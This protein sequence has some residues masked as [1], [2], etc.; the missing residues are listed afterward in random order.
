MKLPIGCCCYGLIGLL[1]LFPKAAQA[2]FPQLKLEVICDSQLDSPI[3]MVSSGDGSGRLFIAEQRGQIRIFQNGM[4]LPGRFL[5]LG[6]LVIPERAGYDERGLLGLAFHPEFAQPAA[7]GAG[8]FYVLYIAP[9]PNA[10]GITTDPVDSRTVLAE[11]K[12]SATDP[13]RADPATARVLLSFDKPQFNHAGGGLAFGPDGML[14]FT[15]GDGGSSNDN[16]F[17]HT[18]GAIPRLTSAKG[19]AQDLTKFFGKMH[20]IDPLGTNGPG[21]QYG[22]PATNPFANPTSGQ[23][24]EI[25]AYGLRNCWRFSFDSRPG[26]TGR[27]FAADVGQNAVEE[28]NIITSGGNY[29]WRNLEGNFVPAF[30]IDAPA[31]TLA[32]TGPIGQ[33][34]HPGVNIGSP[35]LPQLGLSVTGGYVYRGS[36]IPALAGKYVFGD[37]SQSPIL[38]PPPATPSAKGVMLGLEETTPGVWALAQLDIL[39]GNPINRYI[40]GFGQ[41]DSGEL[42]VLTKRTQPVTAPDPA[43]GLPSGAILKIVPVPP[44]T[45]LTLTAAKDNTIFQEAERSNGAGEWI[46]AG[47]TDPSKND[48]AMRRALLGWNLAT[49]PAGAVVASASVTLK[50]DRTIAPAYLFSLHKLTTNWGEGTSSASIQEGDGALASA[51]D[52]TWLKP[53]FGQATPWTNPGG[54]FETRKSATLSVGGETN[55]TW[56]GP[57]LAADA[58]AWLAN[59]AGNF[60]WL[61]K[62]DLESALKTGTG[63]SG[64]LAITVSDTDD[65]V[66]GMG[67]SGTGLGPGAKIAVGGINSSTNVLTLTA[68]NASAV[69]GTIYFAA[70]SA[71][72][73][74]SRSITLSTSRP[75][76]VLTYVPLPAPAS[77]RKA[78]ELTSYLTGQ[79]IEDTYDT[80]GDGIPDGV[81]Y[82]WGFP[83]RTP[84]DPA[85]GFT[86]NPAGVSTGGPVVLT[87]RRDPL[88][89]D[90]T[91]RAQMSTDL[92]DWT[93]LATSA[94]GAVPSGP[95][96]VSEAVV[97][98]AFRNVTVQDNVPQGAARRLYRLK[99]TRL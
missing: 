27:L 21:G 71:K 10:P 80:D 72:R 42:Y 5:D 78:W 20:R 12:V 48:A 95:G 79:F 22:I 97:D 38:S 39:G 82:A 45:S 55:Y 24:P 96:F 92:S 16:N 76:L 57:G 8:R 62:A 65:L 7:P 87:F 4:L 49:V 50:M 41:D 14:Y 40:Q 36:A 13:N 75:R 53:F 30:S 83:P 9:S 60:G 11:Y 63:A 67:V 68:P 52:A 35:A 90:L 6:T 54:D 44:T 15:V 94:A 98:T 25:Y 61:L 43:T 28:V 32:P 91:Y 84:N 58:N 81:E 51:T 59:P 34:A 23:R 74:A 17:G 70:P 3:A 26:G 19:N 18:G 93:D 46:F 88:A 31:M 69:S 99:V 37:W 73:F 47:A 2:A 77:H 64:Q 85:A 33:Y 1:P 56:T 86:V 89:T 66:E 29:G